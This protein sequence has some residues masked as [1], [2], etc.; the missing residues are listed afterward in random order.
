LKL[1]L[2]ILRALLT[3]AICTFVHAHAE[4][5]YVSHSG[6][7][8]FP[9]TTWKTA[10]N[11][12][13]AANLA[14]LPGDTMF[15]DTGSFYLS[16][17]VYTQP[18]ITLRGRGMDSTEVIGSATPEALRLAM[19]VPEDS[20]IVEDIHFIGRGSIHAFA[21]Y[22]T[23][24]WK[25]FRTHRCKFS[26]IDGTP[27]SFSKM[28]Y[29]EI[30]D[31]WF[32]TWESSALSLTERGD[33]VIENNTFDASQIQRT[34]FDFM[35]AIGK[36]YIRNNIFIGG[37]QGGIDGGT[38]GRMEM[39]NNLFYKNLY[40][41]TA[42]WVRENELLFA[43]NSFYMSHPVAG[44]GNVLQI[45]N[46]SRVRSILIYNNVIVDYEPRIGFRYAIPAEAEVQVSH[47]CFF[48][49]NPAA[50]YDFIS[51]ESG[52]VRPDSVYSNI[53]SD[54]ML[55]DPLN[56]DF[57]LQLGS[58][59]I[60]AG[61]PWVLDVDGTRS[62]MGAFGG[63]GG[64]VYAYVDYPPKPPSEFSAWRTGSQVV[65]SWYRNRE[66]DLHHYILFRSEQSP[67]AMDS[68]YVLAYLSPSGKRM[69]ESKPTKHL[70]P[71]GEDDT[72][73]DKSLYEDF[74]PVATPRNLVSIFY[75]DDSA[76]PN[77][78]YSY[79]LVAV[80]SSFLVSAPSDEASVI[81]LS[82]RNEASLEN[83]EL[84]AIEQNFPNPFNAV[85]AI[86]YNLPNIGAQPAPV[87][88]TIYNT[89]GQIVRQLVDE[90]QY[91]GRHV[92]YW[93][94]TDSQGH[95][96]SSGVYLYQLKASGI[97]FIE[98]RKMIVMK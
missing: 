67:V 91:P 18:K 58:P 68:A 31:C 40:L 83:M 21:K 34:F 64:A 47:N 28:V 54:P 23:E 65:L 17:P 73:P 39:T 81:S 98:N 94:G 63:P 20:N 27:I 56:G 22:A 88:I 10:S 97:D 24:S 37:S 66:S 44:S 78:D 25:V 76:D 43:N 75:G 80:D 6:S 33:Y 42:V 72:L 82:T 38:G 26:N 13:E 48:A 74:I 59:C 85:T 70:F 52:A 51:L 11:T 1:K 9:Y 29:V 90:R 61:V 35:F 89:L 5:R 93:D 45:F 16:A 96:V 50:D 69:G 49:T 95:A 32:E 53:R 4:T 2:S 92:A 15:I 7:N 46:D 60:D 77:R 79:L 55:V 12:I 19:F 84:P 71:V 86:V 41:P 30:K 87:E 57:H 62:D 8:T 14:T 3:I 36:K